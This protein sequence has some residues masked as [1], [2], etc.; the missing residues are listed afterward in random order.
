MTEHQD[1][2]DKRREARWEPSEEA[3]EEILR[4]EFKGKNPYPHLKDHG[5]RLFLLRE[6]WKAEEFAINTYGLTKWPDNPHLVSLLNYKEIPFPD[7]PRV[8]KTRGLW[9]S[10]KISKFC[11]YMGNRRRAYF[12]KPGGGNP[13]ERVLV[14]FR[15]AGGALYAVGFTREEAEKFRQQFG[16]RPVPMHGRHCLSQVNGFHSACNC[17]AYVNG[18]GK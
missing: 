3:M 8:R 1:I 18:G 11:R 7:G 12:T 17:G 14:E 15:G 4:V 13:N 16:D 2:F 5:F 6:I 9:T 10:E